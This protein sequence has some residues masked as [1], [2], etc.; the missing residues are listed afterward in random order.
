[1]IPT[2]GWKPMELAPTDGTPIM[3]RYHSRDV[4]NGKFDKSRYLIHPVQWLCDERGKNWQ[5]SSPYRQGS[6]AFALEWMTFEEFQS[7]QADEE[8]PA[9]DFGADQAFDL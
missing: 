4:I 2:K 6:A 9:I 7:A 3:A 8:Q 1:M 5:W